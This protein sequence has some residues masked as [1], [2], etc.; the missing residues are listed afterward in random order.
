MAGQISSKDYSWGEAIDAAMFTI[1]ATRLTTPNHRLPAFKLGL[2]NKQGNILKEPVTPQEL[3]ALTY[4]DRIA[5]LMKKAMG[6][7][8]A[9]IYTMYRKQKANPNFIRAASRA[10]QFG[11]TKY[12]DINIGFVDMR[13]GNPITN[14]GMSFSS[15]LHKPQG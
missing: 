14:A 11:F 4:I 7:R 1:I 12:Y 15:N 9:A 5:L 8:I 2:I 13:G 10:V 3:R 6:G